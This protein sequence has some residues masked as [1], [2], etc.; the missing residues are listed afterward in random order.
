MHIAAINGNNKIIDYLSKNL[1]IDI[2]KR[3]KQ[4]ESALSICEALKNEEGTQ[5]LQ[6]YMDEY[7]TSNAKA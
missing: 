2:F 7:D 6:K 4:G 3:N 1:K 5:I